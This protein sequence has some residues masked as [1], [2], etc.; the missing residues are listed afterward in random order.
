[1]ADFNKYTKEATEI[2]KVRLIAEL[3]RVP[4]WEDDGTGQI[5]K[6]DQ[7]EIKRSG[8]IEATFDSTDGEMDLKIR[9]ELIDVLNDNQVNGLK[10]LLNG[11]ATK[12][13][14]VIDG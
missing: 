4:I 2:R 1:M 5:V 9:K 14:K 7:W 6:T 8:H 10:D 11:L 3:V 13:Q 12:A